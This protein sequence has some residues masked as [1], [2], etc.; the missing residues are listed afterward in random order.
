VLT[1]KQVSYYLSH[2]REKPSMRRMERRIRELPE[3]EREP[4]RRQVYSRVPVPT[5]SLVWILVGFDP[6]AYS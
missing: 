3:S 4:Y 5:E 1:F 6:E 2:F